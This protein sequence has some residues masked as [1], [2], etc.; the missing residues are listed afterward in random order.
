MQDGLY[1]AAYSGKHVPY[2]PTSFLAS[3]WKHAGEHLEGYQQQ[4]AHEF[5]LYTLSGLAHS[6]VSGLRDPQP[7]PRSEE[8]PVC[9]SQTAGAGAGERAV[10]P[11]C[12]AD[13][14]PGMGLL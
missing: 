11:L 4:D 14:V 7:G 5:Y 9:G 1:S 10:P 12:A 8:P 3:W 2:S 13:G 6:L